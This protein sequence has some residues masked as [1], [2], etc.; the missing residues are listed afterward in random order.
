MIK[1][2]TEKSVITDFKLTLKKKPSKKDSFFY[3]A[4]FSDSWE[5]IGFSVF[6][7]TLRYLFLEQKHNKKTAQLIGQPYGFQRKLI[8]I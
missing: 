2:N 3:V 6:C 1:S 5:E 4:N 8:Y 7:A